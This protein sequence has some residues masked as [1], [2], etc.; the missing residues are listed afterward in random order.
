MNEVLYG[1]YT[2]CFPG[3]PVSM[4]T[5]QSVLRPELSHLVYAGHNGEIVGFS[6][7]HGETISLLCVEQHYRNKGYGSYLLSESE[8]YIANSGAGRILLGKGSHYML[9]GVPLDSPD[10]VVFFKNRGYAS[11][12]VSV[13]MTMPLDTFFIKDLD[14]PEKPDSVAFRFADDSDKKLLLEAVSDAEPSWQSIFEDC[15]DPVVLAIHNDKIAGFE[16]ASPYGGRFGL[17]DQKTGSIGCVGV[18]HEARGLGIGRQMVAFGAQWLKNEGCSFVEI[19]YVQLV[20]WYGKIG[21]T[22][23]SRQWM[24]EKNI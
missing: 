18:I 9:Q 5:F 4:E 11:D 20:E 1:L 3:Y 6:M 7:I 23:T 24:G 22:V 10:A 19:L 17:P 21:F 8:K 15:A 16:I 12:W 14:I 13:N 2:R